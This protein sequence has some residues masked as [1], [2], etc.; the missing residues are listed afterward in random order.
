LPDVKFINQYGPTE[1][2][3]SCTYYVVDE[4]VDDDTVLPIGKPYD[5]YRIILLKEDGTQAKNGEIGENLCVRSLRYSRILRCK[6]K[7]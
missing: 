7:N 4:L 5:N 2:T 3:A 1:A 6:R